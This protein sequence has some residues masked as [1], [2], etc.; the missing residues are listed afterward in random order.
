MDY[1]LF[2]QADGHRERIKSEISSAKSV[3]RRMRWRRQKKT[4]K[5]NKK[6]QNEM[7]IFHRFPECWTCPKRLPIVYYIRIIISLRDVL[8][9]IDG[10]FFF[11]F[12]FFFLLMVLPIPNFNH[13][14]EHLTH[15]YNEHWVCVCVPFDV[16]SL[17]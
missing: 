3:I 2:Q 13:L 8:L 17:E 14:T 16:T 7:M 9:P 15:V 12:L 11:F 5:T 6:R 10:F 1:K 4:N